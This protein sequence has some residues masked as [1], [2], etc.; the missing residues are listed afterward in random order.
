MNENLLIIF[1]RNPELGKVKTRLAKTVGNETAL[2]IYKFLLDYTV[3]IT[4]SLNADKAVFYSENVPERDIWDAAIYKKH[5]QQGDD[6][7]QR[8]QNAFE[9]AFKMG[10]KK[11]AVIGSDM[12]ELKQS[13]L[14]EAFA[15]LSNNEVVIGPA[16]DG[17][18]YLLGMTKFIPQAFNKKAWGTET[19][20][21]DTLNDLSD[22]DVKLMNAVL[23]DVDLFEDIEHHAAFKPFLKKSN[24]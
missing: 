13:H 5:L 11:V 19:V 10:Y 21:K 14:E 24:A 8:I 23:N 18:Y 3:K 16:Q 2:N 20:L 4:T 9:N 15:L 12:F 1:T 22:V 6:L 17:G 7:G